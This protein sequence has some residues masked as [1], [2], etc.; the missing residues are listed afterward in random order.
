MMLSDTEPAPEPA[1]RQPAADRD[2]AGTYMQGVNM[3]LE[4]LQ[5]AKR[6]ELLTC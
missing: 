5:L 4:L 6:V 3:R 1:L 2:R